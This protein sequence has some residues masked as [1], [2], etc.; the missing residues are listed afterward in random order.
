MSVD[1]WIMATVNAT[2]FFMVNYD[3][4]NWK[5]LAAQLRKDHQVDIRKSFMVL[6]FFL[7]LILTLTTLTENSR[8]SKTLQNE[9]YLMKVLPGSLYMN[10]RA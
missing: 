5:K 3:Q 1:S 2:G 8:K 7:R 9:Q 10:D 6:T 4:E